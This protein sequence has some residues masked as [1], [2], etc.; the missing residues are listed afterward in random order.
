MRDSCRLD[1]AKNLLVNNGKAMVLFKEAGKD[2]NTIGPNASAGNK[3]EAEGFEKSPEL[4]KVEAEASQDAIAS[5]KTAD[6]FGLSN[7]KAIEPV[8][9]RWTELRKSVATE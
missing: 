8:W 5:A 9:Q 3:A 4:K 6:G 1:V 7:P 2:S